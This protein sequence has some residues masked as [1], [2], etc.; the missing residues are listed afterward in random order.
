L[1]TVNIVERTT[2]N[3]LVEVHIL[4]RVAA[5]LPLL[6]EEHIVDTV[7]IDRTL[8]KGSRG[9]WAQ[10]PRRLDGRRRHPG[11]ATTSS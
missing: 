8:I 10:G 7:R 11:T 6:A 5:G 4:G 2:S 9:L 1:A 3:P